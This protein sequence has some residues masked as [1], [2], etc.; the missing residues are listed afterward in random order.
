MTM[1]KSK[2]NHKSQSSISQKDQGKYR[3]QNLVIKLFC[4][5][6]LYSIYHMTYEFIVN[7]CL[8]I[9]TQA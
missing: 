8:S 3:A 9:E 6:G 1:A 4:L 5:V 2:T 7:P